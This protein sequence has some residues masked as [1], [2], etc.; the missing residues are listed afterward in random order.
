MFLSLG[1]AVVMIAKEAGQIAQ[2]GRGKQD[3]RATR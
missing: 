1:T 3:R 2:G